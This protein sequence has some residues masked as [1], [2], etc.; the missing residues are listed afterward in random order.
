MIIKFLE[1]VRNNKNRI[2]ISQ[3]IQ[4]VKDFDK[5]IIYWIPFVFTNLK[6][7]REFSKASAKAFNLDEKEIDILSCYIYLYKENIEE[8]LIEKYTFELFGNVNIDKNRI[9][10]IINNEE[11]QAYLKEKKEIEKEYVNEFMKYA[12]DFEKDEIV[13]WLPTNNRKTKEFLC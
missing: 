5:E 9:L 2:N 1:N 10:E 6:D 11:K 3:Y 4:K 8:E 7:I 12:K 13:K